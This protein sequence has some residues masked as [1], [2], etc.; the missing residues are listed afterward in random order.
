MLMRSHVNSSSQNS[1][2]IYTT[3]FNVIGSRA[4]IQL[5]KFLVVV[6]VVVTFLTAGAANTH[7]QAWF[8]VSEVLP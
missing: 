1:G 8:E 6:V 5:Q 4:W 3:E 7:A 2:V